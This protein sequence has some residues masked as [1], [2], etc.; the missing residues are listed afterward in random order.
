MPFGVGACLQQ[1]SLLAPGKPACLRQGSAPTLNHASPQPAF[2]PSFSASG[3]RPF[4]S[5]VRR[6]PFP[7]PYPAP[8]SPLSPFTRRIPPVL[9]HSVE[10]STLARALRRGVG[11]RSGRA[12]GRWLALVLRGLG[13][14]RGCF[15]LFRSRA[16]Q[17]GFGLRLPRSAAQA[18]TGGV[19]SAAPPLDQHTRQL[20]RTTCRRSSGTEI[21]QPEKANG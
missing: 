9:L 8:H 13:R 18:P 14:G 20:R 15:P 19:T 4:T 7:H 11:W 6:F 1:A 16:S 21:C 12:G 17:D 5:R 10:S 2:L 3:S